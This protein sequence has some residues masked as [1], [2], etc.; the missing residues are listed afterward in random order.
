MHDQCSD[1]VDITRTI[2]YTVLYFVYEFYLVF[3]YMIWSLLFITTCL[4][5]IPP[6]VESNFKTNLILLNWTV[7][8]TS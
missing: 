3:Y 7:T 2:A 6:A 8:V 4:S 1:S 5:R